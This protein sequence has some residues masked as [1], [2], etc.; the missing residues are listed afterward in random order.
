MRFGLP[1]G[2]RRLGLERLLSPSRRQQEPKP[3][4]PGAISESD[5]PQRERGWFRGFFA[6]FQN[7]ARTRNILGEGGV[8]ARELLNLH[9]TGVIQEPGRCAN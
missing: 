8:G 2:R 7:A 1:G 3:P 4:G 6:F 9:N 5:A